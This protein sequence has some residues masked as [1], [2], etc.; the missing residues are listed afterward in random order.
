MTGQ[1][2]GA[3]GSAEELLRVTR[4]A[5][6]KQTNSEALLLYIEAVSRFGDRRTTARIISELLDFEIPELPDSTLACLGEEAIATL[7]KLPNPGPF[8]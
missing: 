4:N 5:T 8:R 3:I 2:P 1:A 7:E 6:S